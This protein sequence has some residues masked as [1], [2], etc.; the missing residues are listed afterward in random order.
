MIEVRKSFSLELVLLAQSKHYRLLDG[1]LTKSRLSSYVAL[2]PPIPSQTTGWVCPAVVCRKGPW[3][4]RWCNARGTPPAPW[5]D[6]QSGNKTD[7]PERYANQQE[8]SFTARD[9]SDS[10]LSCFTPDFSWCDG[11]CRF[12]SFKS[13]SWEASV[14]PLN[15]VFMLFQS[16]QLCVVVFYTVSRFEFLN[17]SNI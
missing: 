2:D 10:Y 11:R 17:L 14:R 1:I 5:S 8:K 7:D 9:A 15:L 12:H 6:R 13:T 4:P 3:N 16:V